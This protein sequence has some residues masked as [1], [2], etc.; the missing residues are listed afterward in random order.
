MA[1]FS[2][3]TQTQL[4][5]P[6]LNAIKSLGG[7]ARNNE[8][9]SKAIDQEGF[10]EELQ[11][12]MMPN[13]VQTRLEYRLAWARTQLKN[14]HAITNAQLG[15]WT[16]TDKGEAISEADMLD[17]FKDYEVAYFARRA[18]QSDPQSEGAVNSSSETNLND[19]A[20]WSVSLLHKL[21]NMDPGAFERLTQLLLRAV[22]FQSVVVTGKAGDQGID[23]EGIL[24][25]NLITFSVG[26]QCKRYNDAVGPGTV[27]DFQGSIQG[28]HEK[29]LIITTGRFTQA[30][31]DA[32][33]RA[34]VV[35]IDLINGNR[36]CELLAENEL[37]VKKTM[38]PEYKIEPDWYDAI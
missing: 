33:R 32:A 16:I 38:V 12:E 24:Q 8:I 34:G 22:G 11:A 17:Q 6:V 7:S 26:F 13:G 20:E 5:W 3:P 28:K 21:K 19:G 18:E 14:I 25:M 29:G 31:Q 1:D 9:L 2:F 10:S 23:G 27:R 36:L 15:V 30:A 37:G 4:M 35:P